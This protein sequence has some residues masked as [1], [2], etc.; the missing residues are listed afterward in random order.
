MVVM[1]GD[2]DKGG[3][4]EG[5]KDEDW[6]KGVELRPHAPEAS[7]S[8][9]GLVALGLS[10]PCRDTADRQYLPA[11]PVRMPQVSLAEPPSATGWPPGT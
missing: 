3:S 8:L 10:L 9:E 11:A 4:G 2:A 7:W 6:G 5:R 1:G